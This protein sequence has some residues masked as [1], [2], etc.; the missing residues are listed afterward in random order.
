MQIH[1]RHLM[2][3][4]AMVLYKLVISQHLLLQLFHAWL[5]F[6]QVIA[7]DEAA[8]EINDLGDMEFA[9]CRFIQSSSSLNDHQCLV[10]LGIDSDG[11]E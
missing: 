5:V 8:V 3:S 4:Y 7:N 9:M 11:F 10:G 6:E 2:I 1:A